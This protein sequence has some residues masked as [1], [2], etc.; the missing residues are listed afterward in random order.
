MTFGNI[1]YAPY[2]VAVSFSILAVFLFY[3]YRAKR[4]TTVFARSMLNISVLARRV[5]ICCIAFAIP[6]F[7]LAVLAPQWGEVRR[8]IENEGSDVLIALDVSRSMNAE[9]VG[10]SRLERAKNAARRIADSVSGGRVGLIVF[11]GEAFLFCPMTSDR[12]A[13]LMF[14]D[15]AGTDSVNLQGTDIGAV[16]DEAFRVFSKRREN[17][18]LLVLITDG[19]DHEGSADEALKKF[20]EL[21]VSVYCV[22]IGRES[23]SFIPESS[24]GYITGRD[25]SPV[26]SAKNA[27]YLKKLAVDTGGSYF[28]ISDSFSG[29]RS[30]ISA[31]DSQD[32]N[33]YGTRIINEPLERFAF[34]VV[35][36]I[37]LLALE[38]LLPE[39]RRR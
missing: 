4:L 23:G 31:I 3:L 22:G 6:L 32:K 9:D 36:L 2:I 37:F 35:P 8:E 12:G 11:A 17:S 13:F 26:K 10:T 19:E 14:L 30:V 29:L 21:E 7:A 33:Y 1:E 39:A 27:S 20:K 5:K 34:F 15:S 38:L 25:G 18:K 28:D 16:F 24:S